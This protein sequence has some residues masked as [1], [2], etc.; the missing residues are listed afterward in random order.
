[1]DLKS[2]AATDSSFPSIS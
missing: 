1:V 2:F